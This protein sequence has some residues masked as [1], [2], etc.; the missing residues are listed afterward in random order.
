MPDPIPTFTTLVQS[1]ASLHPK[2]A[3]L[4]VI[5]PRFVGDSLLPDT[6]TPQTPESNEFI[7]KI[8]LPRPLLVGGGFSTD[9]P[10]ALK[11]VEEEG[12]VMTFGRAYL[13]NVSDPVSVLRPSRC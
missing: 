1:L 8:W 5:E 13:A 12:V 7:R 6:Y 10:A 4:S 11:A 9:L 3:Y 2:L